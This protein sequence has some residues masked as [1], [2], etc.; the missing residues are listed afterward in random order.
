MADE[1]PE[2]G[3]SRGVR[4]GRPPQRRRLGPLAWAGIGA[5]LGLLIVACAGVLFVQVAWLA[6]LPKVPAADALWS[7]GRTPGITFLDRSGAKLAVRGPRHGSRV[8]ISELPTYVPDAFLAAEDRRFYRHGPVDWWALAR[9]V[10]ANGRAGG[11]VQ[12]GSTLTQQLAKTLFLSPE[13]TLKRKAQEA[14]LAYRLSEMLDRNQILELYLNRVFFGA[15]AYGLE[16]AAETYFGKSAPSLSLAEAAL[17]AALPKAPSRLSPVND[18]AAA[19]ARSH[20]VLRRMVEEG[21]ITPQ[22]EAAAHA[23]PLR[24]V[25]PPSEEEAFGYAL[26]LAQAEAVR[27]AGGKAPDLVVQLTI[28]P[29]LQTQADAIVREVIAKRGVHA[30]ARQAALVALGPDGAVQ[31]LVGGVGHGFSPFNRAVQA[32]RQPGSSFKPFVYA[33]A[34][35]AGVKPTDTRLDAPL[36]LDGWSP[37]NYGGRFSGQVSVQD[38]LARSINT[39]AVRLAKEVGPDRVGDI[40][41]RFGLTTIPIHPGLSVALGAYETSLLELTSG[42]QVFQQGGLRRQPYLVAAITTSGGRT[43]YVH[44]GEPARPVYDPGRA[45]QMTRMMQAVIEHGTGTKAQIGRPA[46]GKTGTSQSWRDAW[47][48]GF[49]PD[50]VCGVWVGNDDGGAMDKV[51]GGDL[52]AEIWRRFMLVAHQD[53]PPREFFTAGP[54]PA[55]ARAAF[56]RGLAEDFAAAA[57]P[58]AS[59]A[60]PAESRP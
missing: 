40:S 56:Y 42:Y 49:T 54:S 41:L 58:T 57:Q 18:M 29:K 9:A 31:A 27:L 37:N 14:A 59:D 7:Y 45:A 17:L 24:L 23:A 5:L 8:A 25:A 16:A 13:Q 12:G 15:N 20:L 36:R 51:T 4:P 52:P 55:A 21:W 43:L 2:F 30:G 53:L 10:V 19:T 34:L 46:A 39:V 6:D 60:A 11:V 48:V 44:G 1:K 28:D 22:Q 3:R 50:W 47:F 32:Q 33:A 26:D 35:E 38:A